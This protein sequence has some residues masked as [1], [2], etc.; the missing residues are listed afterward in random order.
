MDEKLF[1]TF[2]QTE[3]QLN[4]AEQGTLFAHISSIV[5]GIWTNVWKLWAVTEVVHSLQKSV[6]HLE[7]FKKKLES[8]EE[9]HDQIFG[10]NPI[11]LLAPTTTFWYRVSWFLYR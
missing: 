8:L 6:L 10:L 4:S 9:L 2:I 11:L 5:G 7:T 1:I 3:S